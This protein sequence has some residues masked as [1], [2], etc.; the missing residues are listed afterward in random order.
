[1]MELVVVMTII[2]ML[3]FVAAPRFMPRLFEARIDTAARRLASATKYLHA[4]TA[5]TRSTATLHI[6]VAANEYWVTTPYVDEKLGPEEEMAG[7][8]EDQ[9]DVDF[10]DDEFVGS[11]GTVLGM[12]FDLDELIDG[13]EVEEEEMTT[14]FIA[15]TAL[16]KGVRFA[17]LLMPNTRPSE[18]TTE[19]EIEYGPFGLREAAIIV[20]ADDDNRMLRVKLDP[21]LGESSVGDVDDSVLDAL[22]IKAGA[23]KVEIPW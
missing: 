19:F 9:I 3:F 16:P 15:R 11:D 5:L 2:A 13:D 21:V 4:Q 7:W 23:G 18:E 1:M 22:G 10:R 20:L 12:E 8:T 14:E 6:D 17:G